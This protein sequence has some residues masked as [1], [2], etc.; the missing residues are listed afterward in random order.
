[1]LFAVGKVAQVISEAR[2]EMMMPRAWS[3]AGSGGSSV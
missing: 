2:I 1:M 3:A